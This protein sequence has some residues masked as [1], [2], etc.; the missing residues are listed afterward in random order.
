MSSSRHSF[1]PDG[2]APVPPQRSVSRLSD[3][4]VERIARRV[5]DLLRNGDRS[6]SRIPI[7]TFINTAFDPMAGA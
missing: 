7:R 4:D 5:A 6:E 3:E 1:I 2:A